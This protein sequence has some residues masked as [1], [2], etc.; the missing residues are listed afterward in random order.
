MNRMNPKFHLYLENG[1]KEQQLMIL[2][3]QKK[4]MTLNGYYSIQIDG[5]ST[6]RS[7]LCCLGKLRAL[8][9]ERDKYV[10]YDNGESYD[11]KTVSANKANLRKELGA[12]MFRYELCQVG[13]IRKM[14]ILMPQ[15]GCAK[16]DESQNQKDLSVATSV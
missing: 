9:N 5:K 13:N 2:F 10:L 6:K 14:K 16:V 7:S 15:L 4:M 12:F 1:L 8:N 3:A 11:S